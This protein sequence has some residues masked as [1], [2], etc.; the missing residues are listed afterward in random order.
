MSLAEPDRTEVVAWGLAECGTILLLFLSVS[1]ERLKAERVFVVRTRR[2]KI[3]FQLLGI[4]FGACAVSGVLGITHGNEWGYLIGDFYRFA[5]LPVVL[6]LLYFS[7]KNGAG[8]HKLLRGFVAVYGIMVVLD[9][10]RFNSFIREEQ[11]RLTTETAHQAGMIA[12]AVIYLMLFDRNRRV[13]KLSVCLLVLMIVLLLRAQMLTPLITSLMAM[14]LFFCFSRKFAVF[15]GCA[16]AALILVAASFYS[17]SVTPTVPSYIADKLLI[18]QGSQGPMESLEALS[19]V[20]LGEIISIGEEFANHPASLVFGTGEGSLVSPDPI[21]DPA[22]MTSRYTFDKHYVH[23][24]LFDAVYH[25]GI[26]A[27]GA[28]LF[29]LWHLFRR[30][31]RMYD[32]GNPF[33]LFVMVTLM[34]TVVLLSYDLPFESALP[35]LALCFSGVSAMESPPK[36]APAPIAARTARLR[37]DRNHKKIAYRAEDADACAS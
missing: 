15:V 36:L 24:G 34:V 7:V 23:S 6:V 1:L 10:I 9:L 37:V 20:R 4:W 30:G 3:I 29:L 19:G 11:E 27:F 21:L 26:I 22:I 18:A 14:A 13:R 28:F 2:D 33:G 31:R 16:V 5:S 35:M 8:A 12:A 25:N 32:G 17:V